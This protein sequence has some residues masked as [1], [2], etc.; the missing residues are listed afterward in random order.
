[1]YNC[2]IFS[3]PQ[4]HEFEQCSKKSVYMKNGESNRRIKNNI[5]EFHVSGCVIVERTMRTWR[6]RKFDDFLIIFFVMKRANYY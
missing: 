4:A 1:M 6:K 5:S 3:Q 2:A